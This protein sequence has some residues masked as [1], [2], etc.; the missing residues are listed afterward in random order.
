MQTTLMHFANTAD[1]DFF[2]KRVIEFTNWMSFKD[3]NIMSERS[4]R[5]E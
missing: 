2:N 5:T 3:L 4:G 1:D